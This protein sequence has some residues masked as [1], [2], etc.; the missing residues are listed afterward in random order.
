MTARWLFVFV[1]VLVLVLG[2]APRAFAEPEAE[3]ETIIIIDRAPD[4]TT[5]RDRDRALDDAPFVT[6]IHPDEHPATASVADAVGQTA[7]AQT[8]SLGGLGAY[9]SVSV[10]GSAPGQTQ[11]SI[12]GVPL[13]RIAQVTTD[14]GR[15]TLDSF[16][17]VELYRGSVP[18][19]LGGAGVGGA[20][21][22]VTRLGR[23]D[24]GERVRASLGAGSFGARHVHV[25]Y[26]DAHWD[27]KLLSST[28]LGYQRAVGDYT[29]FTDNGT[30]LNKTDD[31]YLTRHNNGFEQ[32]DAATRVGLA[33]Q[34]AAGGLRLAWRDQGLPGS[35]AQPALA[36][37]L[38]TLDVIGDAR[39]DHAIGP[40]LAR[41]LGYVLVES[42]DLHDETGELGLGAQ[43]RHYVTVSGGASSTLRVPVHGDRATAGVDLRAD[44]FRDRDA[45]GA[46]PTVTG[47]RLGGAV[48][49]AYDAALDPTVTVTP[50]VR[51][52]LVHTAPTPMD[53][54]PQAGMAVPARWDVVPSPRVTM[55][56]LAS[57]DVSLKASGGWYV[58]LPTLVEL[59]GDRGYIVGSPTL[60]PER[61]PSAECGAVWAP[62]RALAGGAVD[63]VLVEADVF[64]TRASNTIA[65]ITTAGYV[66][67][68]ANIGESQTSGAE[69]VASL[70]A[71]H[72]LSLTASYTRLASEQISSDPSIAGKPLPRTPADLLYARADL[73]RGRASAWLDAS[74]QSE[75]FLDNAG[76]GRVPG[77]A[78]LGTGARIEIAAHVGISV[79]IANLTDLRVVQLPLSPP[80][81]PTFTST[82]SPLTDVAGYP[83]PGRSYYVSMDWS[84]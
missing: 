52:D 40:A 13:A 43:L 35:I 4:R 26:G 34:R 65:F 84:H 21:N 1:L 49:A 73:A 61:G 64:A 57:P 78:L 47:N 75:S 50:S 60:R 46:G 54:G 71:L 77:R 15:F 55:R 6:V 48:L 44:S 16:G 80:P 58:R 41:E 38:T 42:Q 2:I 23:G 83:L 53:A 25:H 66:A 36:A 51:L 62:A 17:E 12:D 72:A 19:E 45:S 24:H 14:L 33:D 18:V 37:H 9:E 79:S 81:S 82:P 63:R 30:P 27:G 22:L 76:L 39:A 70:R 32:L 56:L 10:R 8:R 31:G 5:A 59:F 11:V 74:V 29:Y 20:L 3:P 69:L 67:R 7:G 68:A 28:T